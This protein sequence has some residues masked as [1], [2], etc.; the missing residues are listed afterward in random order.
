MHCVL[1]QTR[2]PLYDDQSACSTLKASEECQVA[3]T[4]AKICLCKLESAEKRSNLALILDCAM[5][6]LAGSMQIIVRL[7]TGIRQG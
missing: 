4:H 3:L 2:F 7:T 1:G 6:V 5:A